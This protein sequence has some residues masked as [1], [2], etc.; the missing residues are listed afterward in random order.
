MTAKA[1]FSDLMPRIVSAV[2]MVLVGLGC[3]WVGGDAFGVLLIIAAGLM[4][5]EVSRMHTDQQMV[6]FVFGLVIAAVALSAMFLPNFWSFRSFY[7]RSRLLSIPTGVFQ[8]YCSSCQML[9]NTRINVL[10]QPVFTW[11]VCCATPRL[12]HPSSSIPSCPET[13]S[14][15]PAAQAAN[16][17]LRDEPCL[18]LCIFPPLKDRVIRSIYTA[19]RLD[20][21]ASPA[22]C[23]NN[24]RGRCK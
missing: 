11:V 23:A 17:I 19:E 1:D 5:W 8:Y 24:R 15:F 9:G 14:I 3:M 20:Y 7:S 10:P 13:Y 4:G 18:L 6:P 16:I 12:R 2:A 21:R 22:S